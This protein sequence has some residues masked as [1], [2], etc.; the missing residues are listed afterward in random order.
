MNIIIAYLNGSLSKK[1]AIYMI[2]LK[3]LQIK[4]KFKKFCKFFQT[5]YG[6]TRM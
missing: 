4:R 5:I 2:M 1:E 6:F 3:E